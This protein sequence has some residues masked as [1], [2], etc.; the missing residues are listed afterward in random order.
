MGP[1]GRRESWDGDVGEERIYIPLSQTHQAF[2]Q[3][4][5]SGPYFSDCLL[6]VMFRGIIIGPLFKC[7]Q[8]PECN[9]SISDGMASLGKLPE[10]E[11][12]KL[13]ISELMEMLCWCTG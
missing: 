4:V 9:E 11:M 2:L 7:L 12:E 6:E 10:L 13:Q 3:S 5:Q 8:C 1:T